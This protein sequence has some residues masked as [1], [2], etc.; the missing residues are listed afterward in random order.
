MGTKF[1]AS[2]IFTIALAMTFQ[3]QSAVLDCES[4]DQD[5]RITV[6]EISG[7]NGSKDILMSIQDLYAPAASA[8]VVQFLSSQGFLTLGGVSYR[9]VFHESNPLMGP[10]GRRL[11]GTS[12]KFLDFMQLSLDPSYLSFSEKGSMFGA[13]V[14]F[15]KKDGSLF[16]QD[17]TCS[18]FK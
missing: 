16:V 14:T 4:V 5:F 6:R 8:T 2:L 18:L 12:L 15:A 1:L 3:A 17:Y 7:P 13:E 9:A 10:L 11:G